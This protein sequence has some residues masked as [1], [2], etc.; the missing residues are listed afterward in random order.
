MDLVVAASLRV[1]DL[2][3]PHKLPDV[4]AAALQ[5]G[6]DSPSLRLL[7]GLL[8]VESWRSRELFDGALQE[9]NLASVSKVEAARTYAKAVSIQIVAAELSPREGARRLWDASVQVKDDGFHEL[10]PFVYA[11]SKIDSRPAEANSFE[12][13]IIEEARRW[14][15]R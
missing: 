2:L 8:P 15:Q 14:V 13:E 1:L 11:A 4:A 9:L 12:R 6:F 10:D 5:A 7:A 3:P